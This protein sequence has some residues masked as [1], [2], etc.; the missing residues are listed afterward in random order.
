MRRPKMNSDEGFSLIEA[1]VA[2][3]VLAMSAAIV[4]GL[5]INVIAVVKNNGNRQ[6]AANLAAS[7]IDVVRQ[8]DAVTIPDG[9]QSLPS[10]TVGN[11]TY[12]VTQ[13]ATYITSDTSSASACTGSGQLAYKRVTVSVTWPNMGTTKP[14]T[15]QTLRA[16]GYDAAHGGLD[17]TRGAIATAVLNDQGK[18]VPGATVTLTNLAGTPVPG[19]GA[20]VT[21]PDGCAVFAGLTASTT[22]RAQAALAGHVNLDGANTVVDTGNG[23]VANTISKTTLILG[24]PGRLNTVLALK[25]GWL[26]PQTSMGVGLTSTLWPSATTNRV[27]QPCAT[28]PNQVC[29]SGQVVERLLPGAYGAWPGACLDARPSTPMLTNATSGTTTNVNLVPAAVTLR[30]GAASGVN[31]TITAVH[32]ADTLC[33]TGQ[34]LTLGTVPALA[35]TKTIALPAGTWQIRANGVNVTSVT[36]SAN[37]ATPVTVN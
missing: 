15:S 20:Q 36:V 34:T 29:T 6:A 23:V 8:I 3:V 19:V 25:P 13:N 32:A 16:L 22:V 24:Q 30:A 27:P 10:V 9:R 31:K 33:T 28:T 12:A 26:A 35:A 17:A 37:N 1:V 4:A 7:Q 14:V 2:S 11:T 18:P 21:G 5:L